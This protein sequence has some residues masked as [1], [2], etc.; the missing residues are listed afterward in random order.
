MWAGGGP[1][2]A[3]LGWDRALK[4]R[5][6]LKTEGCDLSPSMSS[7]KL[8][9]PW[10]ALVLFSK[11]TDGLGRGSERGLGGKWGPQRPRGSDD[12]AAWAAGGRASPKP[13]GLQTPRA[14]PPRGRSP[15]L[16]R[17]GLA[18]AQPSAAL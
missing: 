10:G 9:G 1:L 4:R 8:A 18:L 13:T 3:G 5:W 16:A 15:S 17:A 7:R 2:E 14:G 11:N 6:T 12:S